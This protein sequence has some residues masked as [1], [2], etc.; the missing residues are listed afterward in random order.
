M[1]S[2][3]SY[4]SDDKCAILGKECFRLALG[5][6][7]DFSIHYRLLTET[8]KDHP[9]ASSLKEKILPEVLENWKKYAVSKSQAGK[10]NMTGS[11]ME[12][13]LRDGA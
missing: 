2:F 13:G 5:R 10:K 11:L 3:C 9:L 8:E 4:L 1:S 12:R 6:K 7:C